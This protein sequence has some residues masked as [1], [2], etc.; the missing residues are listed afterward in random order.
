MM[1]RLWI[2]LGWLVVMLAGCSI[3][4]NNAGS[5]PAVSQQTNPIDWDRNPKTVV[6]RA[7]VTGGNADPFYVRSEIPPCT[8]YGDNHVVWT[9]ELGVNNVQILE[10]RV[11]DE[12]I[13]TFINYVL[14]NKR[15]Y[16]FTA[17]ADTLPLTDN[18]PVYETLTLF[19]NNVLHKTDV[20]GGWDSQYYQ[21]ILLNCRQISSA[22]VLY[23]PS[24]AWI[25]AREVAYDS[26]MPR[27]PW[28]AAANGLSLKDLA[29]SGQPK[30]ITDRNVGVFWTMFL[31]SPK[32][33][34]FMEGDSQFNVALQVPNITRDSPDAP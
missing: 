25:S 26:E 1:K 11:S 29:A 9:N 20:F 10:D 17:K 21:D 13:L 8:I 31:T 16:D 5:P 15:L 7:D 22:P 34:Q 12:K 33:I 24:G 3:G 27:Q 2:G 6:F 23:V 14:L 32:S 28:S 4:G 18:P 30:W 19:V